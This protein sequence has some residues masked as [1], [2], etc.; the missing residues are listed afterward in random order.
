[1][2]GPL[3][4]KATAPGARRLKRL[5]PHVQI[6]PL[7]RSDAVAYHAL[8][9]TMLREYPEAFTSSFEEDSAKPVAWAE[10]R[11]GPNADA[12]HD[13]ILGAFSAAGQL[14]GTV[15][16]SVE[17]RAK[18][19]H[20]A[21]IFGMYVAPEA[22][23]AGVGRALLNACLERAQAIPG[24][25]QVNLT[26]TATSERARRFYEAAGFRAFGVEEHAI[27]VGGTSYPKAHM[28]RY[29][30]K[31]SPP[32]AD[33]SQ[34]LTLVDALTR[35]PD[36]AAARSI[37]VFRHG[38]LQVKWYA[39][40]GTDKQVPHARD[41]AYIVACGSAVFAH[42]AR[43]DACAAGDFLFAAAGVPHRFENFTTDFGVWV[44]FY[45]PEGGEPVQA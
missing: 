30:G 5:W 42:D 31:P 2:L 12:P 23:S 20:K 15:G 35:L 4:C 21:L 44:L 29:L 6:R 39:P 40:R 28:V 24:L 1:M 38:T 26:V 14:I 33:R 16:L 25:A 3:S 10:R 11:I 36:S 43:R 32:A 22:A 17:A 41:E 37:E 45:G 19:R 13:F 18:Q 34:A 7:T 27:K 9:L 8:R